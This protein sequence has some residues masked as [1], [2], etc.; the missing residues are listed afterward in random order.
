MSF[1]SAPGRN[2][3]FLRQTVTKSV[4]R[5]SDCP[6]SAT[7]MMTVLRLYHTPVYARKVSSSYT[8]VYDIL[9]FIDSSFKR[10][11]GRMQMYLHIR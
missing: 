8:K 3:V 7:R 5:S 2:P 10:Y 1:L 4:L 6:L 11:A 9:N